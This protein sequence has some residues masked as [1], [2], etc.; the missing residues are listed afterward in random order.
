M[1]LKNQHCGEFP[2]PLKNLNKFE[3]IE[4]IAW[5]FTDYGGIRLEKKGEG[6]EGEEGGGDGSRRKRTIEEEINNRKIT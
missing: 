5:V 3:R 1:R 4:G 6:K 2:G